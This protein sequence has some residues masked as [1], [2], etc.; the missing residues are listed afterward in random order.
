MLKIFQNGNILNI[1]T[2][3]IK[4]EN[5]LKFFLEQKKVTLL[6]NNDN[7]KD[8]DAITLLLSSKLYELLSDESIGLINY[9]PYKLYDMLKE[10]IGE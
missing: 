9:S 5:K 3:G 4:E 6:I 8:N 2:I 1:N 10:E 7:L